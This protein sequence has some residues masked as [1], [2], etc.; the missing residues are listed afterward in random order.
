MERV[1]AA[2]R[3]VGH[4][5]RLLDLQVFTHS[6]FCRELVAF[7]PHAV[8]FSVN[9]LANV[10]EVLDLA[11]E[12][13]RLLPEAFVFL[14]GRSAPFITPEFL[15]HARGA[16]SSGRRRAGRG[17]AAGLMLSPSATVSGSMASRPWP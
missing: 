8:G 14:G 9:Y 7:K 6:D 10:P 15:D 17:G 2:V 11:K 3:A 5:V 4:D 12:A 13:K 16:R 1:A